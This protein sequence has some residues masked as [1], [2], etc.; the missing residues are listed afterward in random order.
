MPRS[1]H[2]VET[3][4][5]ACRCVYEEGSPPAPSGPETKHGHNGRVV[6]D[7][8]DKKTRYMGYKK[9]HMIAMYKYHT[10]QIYVKSPSPYP[11]LYRRT[12]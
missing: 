7:L 3:G 4:Q 1:G 2:S 8:Q 10:I 12:Q 11:T 6:T 5:P 9:G